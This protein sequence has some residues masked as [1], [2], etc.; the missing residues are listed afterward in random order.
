[1]FVFEGNYTKKLFV[2]S[3][4]SCDDFRAI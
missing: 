1:M 2:S 4:I 3:F